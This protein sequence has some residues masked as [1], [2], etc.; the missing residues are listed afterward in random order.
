MFCVF[1]RLN[2]GYEVVDKVNETG[3]SLAGFEYED[4]RLV[5]IDKNHLLYSDKN[6]TLGFRLS[7]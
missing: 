6:K 7:V 2:K 4:S 5:V 1:N 3:S